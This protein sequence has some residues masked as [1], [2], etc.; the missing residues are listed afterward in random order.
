MMQFW[1]VASF[2]SDFLQNPYFSDD[3]EL[4]FPDSNVQMLT[5][6]PIFQIFSSFRYTFMHYFLYKIGLCF[7]FF[8]L[9]CKEAFQMF[10]K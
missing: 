8:H 10:S 4:N 9:N 7:A 1:P 2:R 6:P 5:S 3:F